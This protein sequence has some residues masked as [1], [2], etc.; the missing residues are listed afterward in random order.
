MWWGGVDED[1]RENRRDV[2]IARDC[3]AR[4]GDMVPV[5]RRNLLADK[6]RLL[7]SVGGVT[8]AVVLIVVVQSL[9]QGYARRIGSLAERVPVDLWIAEADTNGFIYASLIPESRQAEVAA[10]PGVGQV[11]PLYGR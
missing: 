6:V 8:F 11:V 4:T 7:I 5:A 9:Y 2:P 1:G 10:V 3:L